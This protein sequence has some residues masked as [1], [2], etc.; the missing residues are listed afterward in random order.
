MSW[1]PVGFPLLE[2]PEGSLCE[3]ASHRTDGHGVALAAA[4]AFIENRDVSAAP[5]GMRAMAD[6]DVGGFDE[7]PLQ[8]L[9]GLL[10][11]M[12]VAHLTSTGMDLGHD[13]GVAGRCPAVEKRW[14][15]P[16][17]RSMTMAKMSATPGR[18]LSN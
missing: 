3:M 13:T 15:E 2:D 18:V 16:L 4:D 11:Q 17:S 12:A 6:D 10:A 7:G 1:V 5:V 9:V 14:M 8:V